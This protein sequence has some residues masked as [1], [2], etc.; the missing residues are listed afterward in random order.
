MHVTATEAEK[1]AGRT[2]HMQI[3]LPLIFGFILLKAVKAVFAA[4]AD[5][6]PIRTGVRILLIYGQIGIF[7]A[8]RHRINKRFGP[9]R[10]RFSSISS[11]KGES[12]HD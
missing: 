11:G 1:P 6:F 9:S 7:P 3:K 8:R 10:G 2:T 4:F 12:E 5:M